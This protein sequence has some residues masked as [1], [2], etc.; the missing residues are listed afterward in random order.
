MGDWSVKITSYGKFQI[1]YIQKEEKFGRTF[2]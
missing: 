2:S 1:V